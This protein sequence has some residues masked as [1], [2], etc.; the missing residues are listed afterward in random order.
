MFDRVLNTSRFTHF[1]CL[2]P[3]LTQQ[4]FFMITILIFAFAVYE[5]KTARYCICVV[6]SSHNERCVS[7]DIQFISP[8]LRFPNWGQLVRETFSPILAT[9]WM[10]I[11][12]S[13]FFWQDSGGPGR[14]QAI[15]SGSEGIPQSTPRLRETLSLNQL[16]KTN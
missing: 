1:T 15:I 10:K 9:S 3:S 12:K 11:A 8:F 2:S 4:L 7:V 14:V 5:I 13:K 6:F 16:I